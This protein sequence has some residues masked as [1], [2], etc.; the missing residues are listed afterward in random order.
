M[1]KKL[2][3]I[4][5]VSLS[6]ASCSTAKHLY[7]W[8]DYDKTS[9]NYLKN[10]DDESLA[11]FETTLKGLVEPVGRFK[12]EKKNKK[13]VIAPGICAEYG[14]FLLKK[15][16]KNEAVEMFKKEVALFPESKIFIDRILKK[17]EDENS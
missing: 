10:L 13:T 14:Y 5:I 8:N 11:E 15:G 4:G 7:T 3:C 16:K 9:Y 17:L 1:L 2:F 6:I 12:N